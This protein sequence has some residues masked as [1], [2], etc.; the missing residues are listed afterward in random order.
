[1]KT[2]NL[3]FGLIVALITVGGV[4]PRTALANP[5]RHPTNVSTSP[6]LTNEFYL[7]ATNVFTSINTT[8]VRVWV[9][10]DDP[11]GGGGVP[12]QIPSPLIE[13]TE[14]QTVICHFKNLLTNNIE[15][16]SIH[17]HGIELDNDSDGTAVAQDAILTGQTYDYRFIVPRPG[18]Y[19]YHSHMIPGTTTFGGMYGPIIVHD[20]NEPA[21][22][23]AGVLPPTNYTYQLVLTDISFTN[24]AV[25]KV[26]GGTNYTLNALI[27]DCEN[28]VLSGSSVI[29]NAC[30]DAGNPGNVFMCNGSVPNRVGTFSSPTSNSSPVFYVGRN[31]RIRL[32]IFNDSISRNA[33]LTLKYPTGTGNT[34]LYHIGGQGGLLDNAV[35]DGGVQSGYDF[36]YSQGMVNLGSGMR[37]D[38]MFY[39]SGNAGDVIQLLGY[40]LPAAWKLSTAAK[41]GTNYPVAFFVITNG[42]GTNL[43]LAAGS[44]I[45]SA[46]GVTNEDLRTFN[47]NSLAPP[48]VPS[49]G[50]QSGLITLSNSVPVNGVSTGPSIGGYAATAL[51]GN[52]GDGSWP[53][54]PH[55]PTALWAR[56]GD[57]LQLA[58]ANDNGGGAVHPY[59][60]HGFSMQPIAIYSGN[61]QTNL[62]NYPYVQYVDT[63]DVQP[64]EAL[65]FRIKLADR[66]VIADT[67]S[68]GPLVTGTDSPTGGNLGRW[69]MHCHIFLHGAIGMI[70]ELVV[71]PNTVT[72]LVSSGAGTNS[73]IST[74]TSSWTATA[75][76][77]WLHPVQTSG[78]GNSV[79]QFTYDAN[80]GPTRFGTLNIGGLTVQ[81]TQA[82]TTYVQAPGPLT[83]LV[84]NGISVPYG[85]AVDTNGNVFFT[86]SGNGA[87]KEW[88]PSANTVSTLT[89]GWTSPYGL[90]LDSFDNVYFVQYGNA[91]IKK[92]YSGFFPITIT[93]FTNTTP[94]VSGLALDEAG[95]VYITAPNEPA[96]KKWNVSTGILS[97]YTTNG[98]VSPFGVAV[99]K[100]G[101]IYAS[102]VGDSTV[103]K[104]G[105]R[106]ISVFPLII[107]PYWNT[108]IT[109]SDLSNPYN[110]A[111]D[112]GGNIFIGDYSHSAV[113]KYSAASN[114]VTTAVS[115]LSGPTSVAT[116]KTGNI[117]V[118]DWAA[119]AIRE[120]PYAFVDPTPQ[121]EPAEL[122][123]DTLPVVLPPTENLLP[124]FAPTPNSPW[125]FYGGSTAGVVQFAVGA[126]VGGPRSGSITVLGQPITINQDGASSGL[127][128][129]HL[130][131]GPAAG[132]NTV[133]EFVIPTIASWSA[134]TVTPWLHLPALSGTGSSNILFTYDANVGATRVGTLTIDGKSVTITQAGSTYVPALPPATTLVGAGLSEPVDVA[135]DNLGNVI[136][137]DSGNDTVQRWSP[138]GS[139]TLLMSGFIPQGVDVDDA[140]NVYASDF[141]GR[142]IDEWR[143]V[144]S[145]V[146]AL[147]NTPS[148]P[149]GISLDSKTN[150][151]WA[152]P[153]NPSVNEWFAATSNSTVVVGSGLSDP[154]G[155]SVDV[156]GNVY[157][158]DVGA[159][160]LMKWDPVSTT[161]TTLVA[162]GLGFPWDCVVDGSGNVYVAN[163]NSN[164][165]VEWVAASGT[166]VTKVPG[167]LATPTGVSVDANQNIFIADFNDSAVK[168]LPHAFVDPSPKNE[169]AIAGSDALPVVLP[170]NLNLQSPFTPVSSQPWLSIGSIVGGVVNFNFT[171]NTNPLPRSANITLLGRNIPVNQAGTVYPPFLI[172]ASKSNNVFQFTFTNGTPGATYD[173]LFTTN[174]TTP[175][176]NWSLIGNATQIGASLWQFTNNAATNDKGFYSVRSP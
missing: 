155:V 62:F 34:N 152:M 127:G 80:P 35:L 86:D 111:V 22:I 146:V 24:G 81:V 16:A 135:A 17:W 55:P 42:G 109:S 68:G 29:P 94:Y 79:V 75:N 72:R 8:N 171:A 56:A 74:S 14:G 165:I 173:V 145:N 107:I 131:V 11:P 166:L 125:V 61:L 25:G 174:L 19:W 67:A 98:L 129:T 142:S 71:I 65:V 130:L 89:S 73:V 133:T 176:S 140:G 41:I 99:D 3:F 4:A 50:T 36:G 83:G 47:T 59:H 32:Q 116:D 13:L 10:K 158:S 141:Y 124:P 88:N 91:A 147:V 167:N 161:L 149:S 51:D 136:I 126:N 48:P 38:V 163:G 63:M 172:T 53:D 118:A 6:S 85:I 90:G 102:D 150:I 110:L 43:P 76:A 37:E 139:V 21:L 160:A 132:S 93:L 123:V 54:V 7:T 164:S 27:Q 9:Y 97:S 168:E 1:M 117:F 106:V 122:T 33:Y 114:T 156:A 5:L 148:A 87:V 95:N 77:P 52:S 69:L 57:V 20:T 137:A 112:D 46:I 100:A 128:T 144:D 40:G 134:S 84:T 157:I 175:L 70:S 151:F 18:L 159:N 101:G 103:K 119:N 23:A 105:F 64:G 143:A 30:G 49:Y 78:S 82:G 170:Q 31:Q 45:L 44:P 154:R 12:V 120:L 28:G 169:L 115:G 104:L 113:K 108:I 92:R 96:V 58:I 138:N 162:S 121:H 26:E 60:L 2:S 66:P 15:G 153:G 39:S